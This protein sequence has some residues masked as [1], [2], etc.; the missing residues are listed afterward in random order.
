VKSPASPEAVRG[1]SFDMALV[2]SVES[3]VEPVLGVTTCEPAAKPVLGR[4]PGF[5]AAVPLLRAQLAVAKQVISVIK[6]SVRML[7]LLS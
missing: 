5:S 1:A 7:V 4:V 2:G 6:N 3:V